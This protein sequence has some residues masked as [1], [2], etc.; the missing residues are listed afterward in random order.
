ML[1]F[2]DWTR[3]APF[4]VYIFFL[5]I[6]GNVTSHPAWGIDVRWIY[7]AKALLVAALLAYLF[8]HYTELTSQPPELKWGLL[9]AP[10][11]G[12][13]VFYLWIHLDFGIF[14]IGESKGFD[15]R[16]PGT[17]NIDWYLALPRL[18]GAALV[19][20]LM[21]E[22]FWRSFVMRWIDRHDFLSLPP[23]AIS[24]RAIL[25]SSFVFGFEHTQWFA[26]LIAGIAYALLYRSSGNL[27][28]PVIAHG[29]TNGALGIWVL[30]VGAWQFW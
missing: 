24:M 2:Q 14:R 25:I 7:P 28:T 9:W 1:R 12:L 15:P 13:L 10:L 8:R 11:V 23:N 27:W 19:V 26:G 3:I 18:L 21:E 4:A 20:P 29:I 6:E 16:M 22:L 5:F 30:S 17:G